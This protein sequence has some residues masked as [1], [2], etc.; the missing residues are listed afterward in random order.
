M[1]LRGMSYSQIKEQIPVSKSTLSLWLES[2]PLSAE[3]LYELRSAGNS[4][5]V[6][7][8]RETMRKKREVKIATQEQRVTE[9][10]GK[11]SRRELFVA[12]FFLFWGE[13]AKGRRGEVALANTDPAVIR[14][15]LKWLTL[16]GADREKCHFTLHVYADM[17][18]QKEIHYWVKELSVKQGAFYKPYIKKSNLTDITYHNGFGHGTCNARYPSQELNDYVLMG[19]KYIRGLYEQK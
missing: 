17:D 11:L 3:R 16:I 7:A 18:P 14:S 6:E 8:H 9:D 2:Y 10:L 19:L 15:F 12:G 5:R 13:G 1:R 4:H